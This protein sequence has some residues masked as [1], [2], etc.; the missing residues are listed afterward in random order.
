MNPAVIAKN[1]SVTATKMRSP[2]FATCRLE[3]MVDAQKRSGF[4]RA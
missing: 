3:W 2:I 1:P 4:M